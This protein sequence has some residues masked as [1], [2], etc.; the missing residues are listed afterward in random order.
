MRNII[1]Q[2]REMFKS[3]EDGVDI[4]EESFTTALSNYC[5]F[6]GNSPEVSNVVSKMAKNHDIKEYILQRIFF[7]FSLNENIGN[8][9]K[10]PKMP[11]FWD[12]EIEKDFSLIGNFLTLIKCE[13]KLTEI[14][15]KKGIDIFDDTIPLLEND[16]DCKKLKEI[17]K[18]LSP[19]EELFNFRILNNE[20]ILNI[21]KYE[22]KSVS[23]DEESG[24]LY[25]N[26][27]PVKFRKFTEQY[28]CLRI[29]FQ[30]KDDIG[31]EYF[32]SA[33][34][35]EMDFDKGYTNKQFHNYFRAIKTKISSEAG[36]KDLFITTTQ[37]VKINKDYLK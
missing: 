27:N 18:S 3:I 33:I 36:I 17:E 32:F 25:V 30:N 5:S 2:L 20:I 26:K 37:S 34:G 23:F 1:I 11:L 15:G 28:H 12:E 31:Q 9:D 21:E 35:H 29:I 7:Y 24:I 4:S 13:Q 10:K 14:K 16:V 19:K 22:N 8:K 6:I